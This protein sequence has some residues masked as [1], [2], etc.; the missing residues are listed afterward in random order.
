MDKRFR[1]FKPMTSEQLRKNDRILLVVLA[2]GLFFLLRDFFLSA[3]KDIPTLGV[4][5]YLTGPIFTHK[6]SEILLLVFWMPVIWVSNYEMAGVYPNNMPPVRYYRILRYFLLVAP[7][8]VMLATYAW[9]IVNLGTSPL[10]T[11]YE[12]LVYG[13]DGWV[14]RYY[15]AAVIIAGMAFIW[16]ASWKGMRLA[17][18]LETSVS[19]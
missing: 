14:W 12:P 18:W 9:T 13:E 3:A 6:L 2:I 10:T 4:I 7:I 15:L 11:N 5:G 1:I 19:E 8:Q 17:R 16:Y